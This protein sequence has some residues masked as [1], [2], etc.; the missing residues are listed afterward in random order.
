MKKIFEYLRMVLFSAGLLIG[1]QF[2]SFVDQ[3]G[4]RLDA[5]WQE[6][7]TTMQGFKKDADKYFSGDIEKLIKQYQK[8]PDKV[9]NDGGNN[10]A[11]LSARNKQLSNA[12][13]L[14]LE[15]R[16][17]P[18]IQT[19]IKPVTEIRRETWANY[20]FTITLDVFAIVS[21]L[22]C[23]LLIAMLVETLVLLFGLV[24]IRPFTLSRQRRRSHL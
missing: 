2:P 4:K 23:G 13:L 21:G 14:F 18:F 22:S 19:L 12:R 5:H 9:I 6:S 20:S 7:E 1:I 15:N 8:N 24:M 17:S 10:I 11:K 16:L 3:Y